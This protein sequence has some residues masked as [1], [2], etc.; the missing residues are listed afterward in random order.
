[1]FSPKEEDEMNLVLISL[2][3]GF[4]C[5]FLIYSLVVSLSTLEDLKWRDW[6][7]LWPY[8]H[9]LSR[10]KEM[11]SVTIFSFSTVVFSFVFWAQL[12]LS[13]MAGDVAS[14]G[15]CVCYNC[16]ACQKSLKLSRAA[17]AYLGLN[18]EDIEELSKDHLVETNSVANPISK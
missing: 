1:M 10:F 9:W 6:L 7:T 18:A 15:E 8:Q 3:I 16:K 13:T 2:L 12:K 4:I 11:F 17:V 5:T 14:R